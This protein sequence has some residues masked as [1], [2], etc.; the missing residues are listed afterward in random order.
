MKR[1]ALLA[2][3]L[4][5]LSGCAAIPTNTQPKPIGSKDSKASNTVNAPEPSRGADPFQI[6]RDFIE[7]TSNP[8]GSFAAAKAYLTPEAAKNWDT[9]NPT[10]IETSFSTVP[11]SQAPQEKT[12]TVLL[13]G[14]NVGR[15]GNDN[16]FTPQLG[17]FQQ[18]VKLE[19][20]SDGQWRISEPPPGVYMPQNLFSTT[21]RRVTLYFYNP[22][23][24][25]LV[26]DARYVVVPPATSIPFRVTEL[27]TKGPGEALRDTLVSALGPDTEAFSETKESDDGAL[28]VNLTKVGKDLTPEKSKQIVA[29]VVK[30]YS[31]VTTS[32]VRV[33]VEGQQILPDQRD[34]RPSDVSA[35]AG[36]ALLALNSNLQGLVTMDG[37]VRSLAD[38]NPIKGPAGAGAYNAVSAAQ[39]LDGSRLAVVSRGGGQM[40]LR[41][42]ELEGDLSEVD[43]RATTLSRPTWQLSSGP[44]EPGSE[45]WTVVNGSSVARVTRSDNGSWTDKGV[46]ITELAPF[47]SISEL[48]LSRDGTRAALVIAGKLYVA[49][50]VRNN[51]DVALRAPRPVQPSAFG[52][53]VQSIDWLSQDVLVVSS[54]LPSLPVSKVYTDGSKLDR[55]SQS[56]LTVPVGPVAAAPARQVQVIDSSGLWSAAD[57]TD[58]WKSSAIRV[59]PGASVFYPG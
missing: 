2:M 23:F 49:S 47:G 46:N 33:L 11:T 5:T 52:S 43:L 58:V 32:R 19:K 31:G 18:P 20:N 12:Q 39:S 59:S 17:D 25:V 22:E 4:L 15:L 28:E 36:E 57:I 40:R 9:R 10:I 30:S 7:S 27:L 6:V 16:A 51:Q 21:Y 54:S 34:Y 45:V 42:G 41:V 3:V 56:N 55:Y 50:V 1:L 44:K 29:Q 53:S 35:I 14:K 13:Q 37:A 8:G 24:T 26:P 38:G 48:R